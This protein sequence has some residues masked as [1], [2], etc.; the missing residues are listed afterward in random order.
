MA[1]QDA[2]EEV[3]WIRER[4]PRTVIYL[5]RHSGPTGT[6]QLCWEAFR[7][8]TEFGEGFD[9]FHVHGLLTP[10]SSAG[11]RFSIRSG[12]PLILRPFGTLSRYTYSYRRTALKRCYLGLIDRPN[13]SRASAIHFTTAEEREEA[14]WHGMALEDRSFVVPPPLHNL[15][16]RDPRQ[17]NDS[18]LVLFMSRLHPVKGLENLLHAWPAVLLRQP[19][20]KLIIAGGGTTNYVDY[21]K[22]LVHKLGISRS[23]SFEGFVTG[24]RKADLLKSADL[25]VLPSFQENFGVA[26]ME[27]IA[28]GLPVIVGDHVQLASFILE[29][30]LGLVADYNPASL[31]SAILQALNDAP[32]REYCR[33]EGPV[34]IEQEFSLKAVG[35]KLLEMYR[36][37]IANNG[38]LTDNT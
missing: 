11:G 33:K 3:N 24:S 35:V 20:C 1:P 12:K 8:L 15:V 21:L 38:K 36:A 32:F 17:A 4:L 6:I 18:P 37:A 25:F 27:A 30:K 22:G 23:V 10:L 26:A 7:W 2:P 13:L 31:A 5:L 14:G 9:A 29:K 28:A 34:A 19:G 16:M